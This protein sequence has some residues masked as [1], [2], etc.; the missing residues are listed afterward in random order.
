MK[1]ALRKIVLLGFLTATAFYVDAQ[2][3]CQTC[4]AFVSDC[5][6]FCSTRGGIREIS[7]GPNEEGCAVGECW[8]NGS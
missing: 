6:D 8:C 3:M 2:P 5:I 1:K 4:D 7:C